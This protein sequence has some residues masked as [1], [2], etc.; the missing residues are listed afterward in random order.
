MAL[1]QTK[2]KQELQKFG[3]SLYG[4]FV[5]YPATIA[6]AKVAWGDAFQNYLGDMEV[7][8][9]GTVSPK[10]TSTDESGCSSAFQGPLV[11]DNTGSST[12]IT[13]AT[14]IS[15]AWEAAMNAIVMVPGADYVPSGPIVSIVPF[16]A[17]TIASEKTTLKSTLITIFSDIN[18]SSETQLGLIA[19]AMHT[20]TMNSIAT[21]CD[22]T[23]PSPPPATLT[24]P[25]QFG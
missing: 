6:A 13:G 22:Y 10:D 21:S 4:G 14:E 20:A 19:T 5:A 18:Q 15:N 24:G 23:N 1:T 2:L 8:S 12:P 25:L 7:V 9:P 3:D 11:F 17:A 16:N